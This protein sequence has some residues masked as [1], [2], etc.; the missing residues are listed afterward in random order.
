MRAMQSAPLFGILFCIPS[1]ELFNPAGRI[2]QLLL[3]GE[4]TVTL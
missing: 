2:N 1:L 3:A 4:K